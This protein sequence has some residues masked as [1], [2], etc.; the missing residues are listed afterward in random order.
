MLKRLLRLLPAERIEGYQ[1]PELI[2]VVVRKTVAYQPVERLDVGGVK[3]VLDF[4]GGAGRHFKEA[5]NG[6]E[7]LRWAV[8]ETAAMV[9][10]AKELETVNL[11]FFASISEAASWLGDVEL[12]HSNGALQYVPDPL[13]TLSELCRLNARAMVWSRLLLSDRTETTTQ[14]SRLVDNGPGHLPGLANKKVSYPRTKIAESDFID[15]HAG[16]S[17]AARGPDWFRF[18]K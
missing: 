13:S 9:K 1:H 18:V 5:E 12:I 10:H 6:A 7:G 15:A 14:I 2:D 17:V 16:Y 11:R 3:S 8:V 4:G